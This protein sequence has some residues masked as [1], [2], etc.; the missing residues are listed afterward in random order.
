VQNFG[1]I[2]FPLIIFGSF[3]VPDNFRNF[4]VFLMVI[5]LHVT[6]RDTS[7]PDMSLPSEDT[8]IGTDAKIFS[9]N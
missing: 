5:R 1:Q 8:Y 7:I 9:T 3:V 2:D 6:K 4:M